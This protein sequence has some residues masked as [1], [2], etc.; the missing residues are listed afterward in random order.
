MG[1]KLSVRRDPYG[2]WLHHLRN[3][4]NLSQQEL[5]KLTGIP[6][7]TLAYWEKTGKLT[8]RAGILRLA[9]ALEVSVDELLRTDKR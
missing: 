4:R 5:A 3:E 2:A 8:G 1:R 6:Q 9:E 7:T